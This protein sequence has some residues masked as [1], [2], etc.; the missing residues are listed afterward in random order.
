V[1]RLH[2][3]GEEAQEGF[4]RRLARLL[5]G[6]WTVH[7]HGDLG[8]GKTTLVRGILR[9][10]G[11]TG[12]VKSP[13]Y[14]LIEPYEPGGRP[15]FHLD[16][17]RLG[18][19]EEIEYLGLRDLLGG[20]RL[21]LVEW[22]ERAGTALP[23]A[24]LDIDIAYAGAGRDLEVRGPGPRAEALIRALGEVPACATDVG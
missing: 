23:P 20:G 11:H 13:T 9:G 4:G 18:D 10:L 19:P 8:T 14:T 16:L 22:P 17:Y 3:E 15:V 5:E 12:A 6:G 24:D 21:L 1:I 2:L 7:L